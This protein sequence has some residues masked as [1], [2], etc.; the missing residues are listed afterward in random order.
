M[1]LWQR[2]AVASQHI[3]KKEKEMLVK[4]MMQRHNVIGTVE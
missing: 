4:Y 3:R 1:L 2:Y